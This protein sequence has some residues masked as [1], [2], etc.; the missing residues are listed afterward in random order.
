VERLTVYRHFPEERALL[1]ACSA[2]YTADNPPPDPG[3][4]S[5]VRDPEERLSQALA[6]VYSYYRRTEPMVS[7]SVRDA[8]LKP[9]IFEVLAPFFAHWERMRDV[10]AVGWGVRGRRRELL[11]A[12]IAHALDFGTWQSLVRQQG[13]DDEGAIEV[14]VEMVRCVARRS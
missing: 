11:L 13:L 6:E 3:P 8:P 2:Q 4:W 7:S 9:V 5:G 1:S 14:M 12:A 10:L